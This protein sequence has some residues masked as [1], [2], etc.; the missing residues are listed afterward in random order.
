MNRELRKKIKNDFKEDIL[1]LINNFSEN[2]L[3]TGMKKK[4][5]FMNKLSTIYIK[6]KQNSNV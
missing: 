1:K 4:Q 3:D 2:S 5:I 6:I